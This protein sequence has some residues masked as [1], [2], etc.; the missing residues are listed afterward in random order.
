MSA[1][2]YKFD[3][4]A[5]SKVTY[6]KIAVGMVTNYFAGSIDETVVGPRIS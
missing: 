4:A 3:N 5:K 1:S 6:H 2:F